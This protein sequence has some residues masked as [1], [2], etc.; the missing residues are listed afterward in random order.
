MIVNVCAMIGVF[1]GRVVG[2]ISL[3]EA[4]FNILR[5]CGRKRGGEARGGGAFGTKKCSL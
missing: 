4:K 5:G 1:W 3:S 2:Y